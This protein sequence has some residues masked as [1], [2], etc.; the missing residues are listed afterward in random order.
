MKKYILILI[1]LL[2]ICNLYSYSSFY[3]N[4]MEKQE[5]VSDENNKYY[6]IKLKDVT[7]ICWGI[8]NQNG[9][10][11]KIKFKNETDYNNWWATK[12]EARFDYSLCRQEVS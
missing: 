4:F 12:T 8:V 5:D 7:G 3:Q 10:L 11:K 9:V 1:I 6:G 2:S